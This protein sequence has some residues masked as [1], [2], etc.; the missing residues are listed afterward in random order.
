MIGL[1]QNGSAFSQ[2][3]P[4]PPLGKSASATTLPG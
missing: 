4:L 3:G 2:A 1:I